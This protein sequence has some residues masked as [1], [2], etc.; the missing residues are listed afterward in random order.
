MSSGFL[1]RLAIALGV[2]L[3]IWLGAR[4]VRGFGRGGGPAFALTKIDKGGVDAI[5]IERATDTVRLAK[6]GAGW[7][8]N[9]WKAAPGGVDDLLFALTDSTAR[10]EVV[11]ENAG[12]HPKLGVDSASGRRVTAKQGTKSLATYW[13]GKRGANYESG[14]VRVPGHNTVYQVKGRLVEFADRSPDDWRDKTIAAVEPDSLTAVEVQ[15]GKQSYRL[16]K[17]G[18]QWKL[19]EA[20]ADSS[21]VASLLSHFKKLDATGFASKAEAD[22]AKFEPPDRL[23]RLFGPGGRPLAVLA[24]DSSSSG[25][26]VKRDTS[27]VVY[28]VDQWT[29]GQLAPADSSLRKK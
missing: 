27:S 24:F 20:A 1:R 26:W 22:S 15:R 10:G 8:V 18:K 25:F 4:V 13:V 29:V 5:V 7:T 23:I 12:S 17:D 9:G 14:Y 11:A 16:S 6:Q 21:Q 28:R 3:A 19:G 2:L